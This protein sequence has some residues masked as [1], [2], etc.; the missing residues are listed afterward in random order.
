MKG[1]AGNVHPK[2]TSGNPI[3]RRLMAGFTRSAGSLLARCEGRSVLD[4]GCGR[5]ELWE[6][7][8][9]M[10]PGWDLS[11][12]DLHRPQVET[13]RSTLNPRLAIT[14][15]AESLPF[16]DDS[17]DL[18]TSFE[19][20]EHLVDPEAGLRELCRVSRSAILVSVPREPLWRVLNLARGAYWRSGGNTPGHWNHWGVRGFL[21]FL[22][23]QATPIGLERPLPWI[24]VLARINAA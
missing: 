18:V 9:E 3:T 13:A 17:F 5:G 7:L 10:H 14:G 6:H 11:L 2:Y 12:L 8:S 21:R 4:V 24:M 23:S 20:L 15:S 22:S 19:T 1:P 16:P